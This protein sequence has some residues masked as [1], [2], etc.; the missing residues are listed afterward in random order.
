MHSLGYGLKVWGCMLFISCIYIGITLAVGASTS[1]EKTPGEKKK[2]VPTG[3]P[4][5]PCKWLQQG[6]EC[7]GWRNGNCLFKHEGV[8]KQ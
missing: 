8:T 2:F 1:V 3:D 5:K 7:Y 4:N 6:F